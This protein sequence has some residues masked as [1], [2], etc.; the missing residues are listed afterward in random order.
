M[1][2][3][4]NQAWVTS[5]AQSQKRKDVLRKNVSPL[6]RYRNNVPVSCCH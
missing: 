2:M 5:E 6:V 3:R 4:V 1:R